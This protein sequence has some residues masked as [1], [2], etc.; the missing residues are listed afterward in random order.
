M[1]DPEVFKKMGEIMEPEVIAFAAQISH[2]MS[3]A[4]QA[5]QQSVIDFRDKEIAELK[6]EIEFLEKRLRGIIQRVNWMLY[7]GEIPSSG[8][9]EE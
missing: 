7:G 4:T 3:Q 5:A 8:G 1:T 2:T 9:F 6:E